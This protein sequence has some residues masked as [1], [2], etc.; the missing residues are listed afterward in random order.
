MEISKTEDLNTLIR[1]AEKH[2]A[3]RG[4]RLTAK[5]KQVLT[6][7]IRSDRALSAYELV[8]FCK[9]QFGE[10]LSAMST[11][12]I[13]DFLEQMHLAHKLNSTNKFVACEHICRDHEHGVPQF[14]ICHKCNSIKELTINPSTMTHIATDAHNEGFTLLSPQLEINCLCEACANQDA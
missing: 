9:Q 8:D 13:L 1:H 6:G 4:T 11:Y 7:L 10:S 2:C 5:R 12:R 14:L 3:A